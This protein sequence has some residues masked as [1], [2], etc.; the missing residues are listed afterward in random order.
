WS[1][2]DGIDAGNGENRLGVG[3]GLDM[4]ALENDENLVV[5]VTVIIGGGRIE[6]ERMHAAADTAVAERWILGSGHRSQ[7][8][9]AT[10]YHGHDDTVGAVVENTL[11]MVVAIGRHARQGRATSVGDA[12]K[13]VGGRFP[14][15]QAVLDVHRQPGKS[16][17][18]QETRRGN[19]SQGQPR[20]N[21]WL[22]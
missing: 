6:V 2:K 8:L 21:G 7:R 16:S 17:S 10:V 19:A 9:F 5:G 11:D 12:G 15:N 20:T 1:D 14:I 13:H 4:F 3:H 22:S 18:G